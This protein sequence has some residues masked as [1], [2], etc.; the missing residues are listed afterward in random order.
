[1]FDVAVSFPVSEQILL[2]MRGLRI[3]SFNDGSVELAT[4]GRAYNLLLLL[5]ILLVAC[6]DDVRPNDAGADADAVDADEPDDD[7][8]DGGRG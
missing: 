8:M 7:A 5:G 4:A 3:R 1:M 2:V 6:D